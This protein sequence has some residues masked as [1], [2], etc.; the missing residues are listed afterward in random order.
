[1]IQRANI[2]EELNELNSS[3]TTDNQ[4]AV[5]TV[6]NGYFDQLADSVLARI[7]AL[8]AM[9]AQEEINHL[10]PLLAG[11]SKQMPYSLPENYFTELDITAATQSYTS[12]KDELENLSPLLGGL[13]KEMPYSV[14]A[15][16]FE[17]VQVPQQEK[18]KVISL[19]SR[20]WFRYAA[21]AVVTGIIATTVFVVNRNN[22]PEQ[23]MARIENTATKAIEKTSEDEL[24][25][26]I[27]Y[28]TTEQVV[29]AKTNPSEDVKDMLKGIPA[30]DLQAFLNEVGD[31]D[32]LN[33]GMD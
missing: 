14:P 25:D 16:Y 5:Y 9:T 23:K 24:N 6:P 8:E 12:A 1:M 15:G 29:I 10:S 19:T 21:A 31:P 17:N 28:S 13:K 2:L 4:Q 30:E 26:F 22:N 32:L 27:Q 7:K 3:L 11:A 18:A 33:D 20:K